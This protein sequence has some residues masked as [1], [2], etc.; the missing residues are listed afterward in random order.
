[1]QLW[2]GD[3]NALTRSDYDVDAWDRIGKHRAESKW[4]VPVD[5]VCHAMTST[6]GGASSGGN[7]APRNKPHGK[8]R[9][10]RST[11]SAG[12]LSLGFT[13]CWSAAAE[14]A[15]PLGTSRF[16]TRIDYVYMSDALA[17]CTRVLRCEHVE[18]ISLASDHNG[19]LV[20]LECRTNPKKEKKRSKTTC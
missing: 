5:A 8:P 12:G 20:T 17:C 6:S 19:V 14:R 16:N 4:E 2:L 9:G 10:R 13:D 15:G 11:N 3:F 7:T 1:M 18:T